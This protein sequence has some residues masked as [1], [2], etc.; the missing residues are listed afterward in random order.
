MAR[1]KIDF[2]HQMDSLAAD[3]RKLLFE[4]WDPARVNHNDYMLGAY[5]EHVPTIYK[6]VVFGHSVEE[7]C[8]QLNFIEKAALRLDPRKEV[9]RG[10][11]EKL[12]VLGVARRGP[13]GSTVARRLNHSTILVSMPP[14]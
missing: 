14:H 10:L 3:I 11:A 4:Q 5:D 9:N 12:F 2:V 6:L 7:I 8:A 1:A 13:A